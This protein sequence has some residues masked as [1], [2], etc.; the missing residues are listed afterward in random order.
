MNTERPTIL[1]DPRAGS[2]A[3]KP[4]L[5]ALGAH[6]DDSAQ[7][8]AD[9]AFAGYGPDGVIPIGGEYKLTVSGVAKV[10]KERVASGDIFTSLSDGRLNGTQLPRMCGVY[11]RRYLLIEGP[12]R[13]AEDGTL[14][15]LTGTGDWLKARGRGDGG[16][17]AHEYWARLSS[18]AEFFSAPSIEG[19]TEIKHTYGKR[20]SAAW[21]IAMWHYWN[22]PYEAHS[23]YRQFDQSRSADHARQVSASGFARL[24]LVPTSELPLAQ[25]MAAQLD[26]IGEGYS[27]YVAK[28]FSTPAEMILADASLEEIGAVLSKGR[29]WRDVECLQKLKGKPGYRAIHFSK[30]RIAKIREQLWGASNNAL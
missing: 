25:R 4:Y 8:P 19:R 17:T 11:P 10:G 23:S 16:W 30:E 24:D 22:K 14:E 6:V 7:I 13:T 26:G 5:K 12:T 20:E 28:H 21:I 9:F 2:S 27:G 1:L 3:L 29:S 18:I 15:V